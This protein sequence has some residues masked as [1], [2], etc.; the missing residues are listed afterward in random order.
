MQRN[1]LPILLAVPCIAHPAIFTLCI[2]TVGRCKGPQSFRGLT[3]AGQG[4]I[5]GRGG[6]GEKPL[7]GFATTGPF[8]Y[9]RS[10]HYPQK[11]RELL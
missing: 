1:V 6:E 4:V 8:R 3:L 5:V 7:E 2:Y 11:K 10:I 9:T